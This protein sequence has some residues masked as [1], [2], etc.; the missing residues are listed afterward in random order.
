MELIRHLM[1]GLPLADGDDGGVLVFVEGQDVPSP[2][3]AQGGQQGGN[4]DDEDHVQQGPRGAAAPVAPLFPRSR[5]AAVGTG[6]PGRLPAAL[7][8]SSCIHSV[9]SPR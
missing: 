8:S 3:P 9:K 1:E 5:G 7:L 2:H 6:L 4:A